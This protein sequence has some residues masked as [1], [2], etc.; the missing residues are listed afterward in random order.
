MHAYTPGSM[1]GKWTTKVK[2]T[3]TNKKKKKRVKVSQIL[4]NH[5]L[6]YQITIP[7]QKTKKNKR[8]TRQGACVDSGQPKLKRQK[9][10]NKQTK[11]KQRKKKSES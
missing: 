6:T 4:A 2:K 8:C 5:I 1:C 10:T 9:Q 7:H 11:N 3:K